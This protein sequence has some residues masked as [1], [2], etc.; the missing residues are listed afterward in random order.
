MNVEKKVVNIQ[1]IYEPLKK[2]KKKK[3][4]KDNQDGEQQGKQRRWVDIPSRMKINIKFIYLILEIK[5][6]F[7]TC[8]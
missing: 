6:L 4:R 2:Q 3:I 8:V 1:P 7:G 5:G